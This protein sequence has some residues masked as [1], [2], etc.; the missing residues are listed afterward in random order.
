MSTAHTTQ[1]HQEVCAPVRLVSPVV[2]AGLGGAHVEDAG[3]VDQRAQR[4]PVGALVPG[5]GESTN[6]VERRQVQRGNLKRR[7]RR[8]CGGS[9]GAKRRSQLLAAAGGAAREHDCV[10][11]VSAL[12]RVQ[13]MRNGTHRARPCGPRRRQ[14]PSRCRCAPDTGRSG[15]WKASGA[16]NTARGRRGTRCVAAQ[17]HP[18]RLR[19]APGGPRHD[20]G[21]PRHVI[22]QILGA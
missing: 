17:G 20:E 5:G 11:R 21:A 19:G 12:Q 1:S 22:A 15:A 2:A 18:A 4:P 3:V 8:A 13:P 9:L 7:R 14:S 6:A 10:E 16:A